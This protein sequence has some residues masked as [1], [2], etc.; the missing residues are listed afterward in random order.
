MDDNILEFITTLLPPPHKELLNIIFCNCTKDCGTNCGC[1]NIG[2]NCSIICE[3]FRNQSCLNS[4][5]TNDL[6]KNIDNNR[7]PYEYEDINPLEY[8]TED[9]PEKNDAGKDQENEEE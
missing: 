2:V 7:R 4:S 6:D 5:S 3:H 1:R 8:L 9:I